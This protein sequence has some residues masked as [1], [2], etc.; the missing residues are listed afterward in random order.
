MA[1]VFAGITPHPP[2]LIPAIG[3]ETGL[4]Q[5]AKTKTALEQLEQD[6]YLAK[7]QVLIVL[8]PHEGRYDD[9][10]VVNGHTT[11]KTSFEDFGAAVTSDTLRGSPD[12]AAKIGHAGREEAFDIRVISE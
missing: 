2:A 9:A 1:L 11:F 12:L 6:L 7:T 10:F 3:K 4:M 5:L 8:S